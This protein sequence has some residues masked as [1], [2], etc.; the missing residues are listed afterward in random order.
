MSALRRTGWIFLFA[1]ALMLLARL[2]KV[3]EGAAP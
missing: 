1:V 2:L 3:L